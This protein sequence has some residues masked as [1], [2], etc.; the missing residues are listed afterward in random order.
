[1]IFLEKPFTY[2]GIY[3]GDYDLI[4]AN[5]D[6]SAINQLSGEISGQTV[7]NKRTKQRYLVG[8]DYSNSPISFDIDIVTKNASF[9]NE[10]NRR[11]IEKWLFNR[12]S[13]RRLDI[14]NSCEGVDS[15]IKNVF[16][17]C[18][19]V[20]PRYIE[21]AYGIIGYNVTVELDSGWAYEE[22]TIEEYTFTDGDSS[23]MN[24]FSINVDTDI[25]D[26]IYPRVDVTMGSTGGSFIM[27]NQTDNSSRFTSITNIAG[28]GSVAMRGD[29]NYISGN[30]YS[31]FAHSNFV[32]LLDGK[33][34]FTITGNVV[35]VKFTWNNRRN[36]W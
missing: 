7:F 9:I 5:V 21:T 11:E 34:N 2:A 28:G 4:F 31:D 30:H 20:S 24:L 35:R 19:F 33:N 25:D 1:M 26:Y 22:E 36:I 17:M 6:S 16:M 32:R 10:Y 14:D 27:V 12:H 8:D 15:D 29:I 23:T 3:S 13:Y 18:R